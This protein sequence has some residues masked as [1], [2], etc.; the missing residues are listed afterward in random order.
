M[1]TTMTKRRRKQ[2]WEQRFEVLA[3]LE[4]LTRAMLRARY[5]RAVKL[6]AV[7]LAENIR[8]ELERR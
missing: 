5:I 1:E 2:K 4:T 8:R 3:K 6:G 7:E